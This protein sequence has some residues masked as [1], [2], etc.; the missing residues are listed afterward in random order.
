MLCNRTAITQNFLAIESRPPHEEILGMSK[1][2]LHFLEK[3]FLYS[4]YTRQN[5]EFGYQVVFYSNI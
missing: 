1:H 5:S 4:G 3:Y 2:K